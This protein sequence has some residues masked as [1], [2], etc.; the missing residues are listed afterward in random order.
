M[1]GAPDNCAAQMSL[2][3]TLS[4]QRARELE[5]GVENFSDV[6]ADRRAA[7]AQCA[8][9]EARVLDLHGELR[10]GG[11]G[12]GCECDPA[13]LRGPTLGEDRV[14]APIERHPRAGNSGMLAVGQTIVVEHGYAKAP[15]IASA[16]GLD[17]E[18]A[19]VDHR[20][21]EDTL[22]SRALGLTRGVSLELDAL[23]RHPVI[24]SNDEQC[25]FE[26]AARAEYLDHRAD[27]LVGSIERLA[28]SLVMRAVVVT[29]AVGERELVRNEDW[30]LVGAMR[31]QFDRLRHP[32]NVHDLFTIQAGLLVGCPARAHV[33]GHFRS[34][35]LEAIFVADDSA[36]ECGVIGAA[37]LRLV[38]RRGDRTGAA[39]AL[40]DLVQRLDI[41]AQ[42]ALGLKGVA[43]NRHG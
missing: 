19:Q 38:D 39:F 25:R 21:G 20:L 4:R 32:A 30:W 34:K 33:R 28:Q 10:V 29:G 41:G 11:V 27:S 1:C 14:A 13:A 15:Q 18:I 42:E 17:P 35:R 23:R 36:L 2:T 43:L 3:L 12:R 8:M 37:S 24:G 5:I 31:E 26:Q 40:E 16:L 9:V 22:N 7:A 6:D